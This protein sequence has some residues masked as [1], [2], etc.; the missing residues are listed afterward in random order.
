MTT[1]GVHTTE[2]ASK[3]NNKGTLSKYD[4]LGGGGR[5]RSPRGK[6]PT[7]TMRCGVNTFVSTHL[8]NVDLCDCLLQAMAC[9]LKEI[10]VSELEIRERLAQHCN[11]GPFNTG[12]LLPQACCHLMKERVILLWAGLENK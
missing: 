11:L 5:G 4:I 6:P 2:H 10:S 7:C 12:D 1:R 3:N 8:A 9:S